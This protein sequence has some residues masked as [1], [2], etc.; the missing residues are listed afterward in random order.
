MSAIGNFRKEGI[1]QAALEVAL[2]IFGVLV[3]LALQSWWEGRVEQSTLRNYLVALEQEA[4]NNSARID[5]YL[6]K[7][8]E[9]LVETD[10]LIEN[11]AKPEPAD[12]PDGFSQMLGRV[13]WIHGPALD[14][15]AHHDIV[16]SGNLRLI[17]DHD[18]RRSI[19]RYAAAVSWAS[20]ITSETWRNYYD[21]QLP[22]LVKYADFGEFDLESGY[23]RFTNSGGDFWLTPTPKSP[24]SIDRDAFRSREFWNLLYSWKTA[25]YDQGLGA[26]MAKDQIAETLVLLRSEIDRLDR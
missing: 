3:A 17:S 24:H 5:E 14:L 12:L 4:A 9:L 21:H 23:R 1:A 13:Y 20:E 15:D 10:S 7:Y 16:S 11:L 18:L 2:I 6:E 22:F 8:R 25:Q 26:I 19:A